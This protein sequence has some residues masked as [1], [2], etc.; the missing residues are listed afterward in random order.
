MWRTLF[1]CVDAFGRQPFQPAEGPDEA[2]GVGH[3]GDGPGDAVGE[4]DGLNGVESGDLEY[5]EDPQDPQT[6]GAQQRHDGGHDRI[7]EAADG[8]AENFHNAAHR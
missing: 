7:A 6:A 1:S 8:I 4:I 5:R 2:D 3:S